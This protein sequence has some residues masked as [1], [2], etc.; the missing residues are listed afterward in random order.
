M[1]VS[2]LISALKIGHELPNPTTAKWFGLAVTGCSILLSS[3]GSF[4]LSRGWLSGVLSPDEVYQLTGFLVTSVLTA[5]GY[6]QVATTKKVGLGEDL[7]ATE[8]RDLDP[9][10]TSGP[11]AA[12]PGDT[13]A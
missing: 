1:R 6:V 4:A 3:V 11:S 9:V 12:D 10:T 2:D 7:R 8:D 5:L 13:H